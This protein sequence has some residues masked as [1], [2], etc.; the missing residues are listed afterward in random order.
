VT[1]DVLA[2][3]TPV[4]RGLVV[5]LIRG[6]DRHLLLRQVALNVRPLFRVVILQVVKLLLVAVDH[7]LVLPDLD[8]GGLE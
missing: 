4:L 8:H 3:F 6:F 5:E 2:L 1:E 7:D